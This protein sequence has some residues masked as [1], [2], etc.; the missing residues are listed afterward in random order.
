MSTLLECI[1]A[2]QTPQLFS[3]L[4]ARTGVPDEKIRTGMNAA[5]G[6]VMEALAIKAH[7]PRAMAEAAAVIAAAPDLDDPI[8]VLEEGAPVRQSGSK[9]L[10]L[11]TRDVP[12]LRD[13]LSRMLGLGAG[14]TMSLLGAASG[15]VVGA[16]RRFTHSVGD[17][18][19]G[20][21]LS[22]ALLEERP[23][24]HAA[25]PVELTMPHEHVARPSVRPSE[26]STFRKARY[27]RHH[28]NSW[29]PLLALIPLALIALWIATQRTD[30]TDDS[31]ATAPVVRESATTEPGSTEP[32]RLAPV[33]D[34]PPSPEEP[35][36]PVEVTQ[37]V[38][39][40]ELPDSSTTP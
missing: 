1:Q 40:I 7:H 27:H 14:T 21:T 19:D 9:L 35:S 38:P 11:A 31:V 28:S 26:R 34:V 3:S 39:A 30:R 4:A 32:N 24:L 18:V 29:L 23:A 8:V 13:H 22:S 5:T 12:G 36:I 20:S 10:H 2:M 15:L 37:R 6:A 16:L 33:I 25:M 17:P